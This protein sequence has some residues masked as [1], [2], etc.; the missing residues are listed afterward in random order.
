MRPDPVDS[1]LGGL[2]GEAVR[3]SRRGRLSRFIVDETSPAIALFDAGAP[4]GQRRR[5]L[6]RR[7]RR[8]VG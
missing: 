6:V 2:L 5:R 8:Q 4:A 1:E 7:T 3:A